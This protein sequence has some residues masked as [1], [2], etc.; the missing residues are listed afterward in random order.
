[1]LERQARI[2]ISGCM[3]KVPVFIYRVASSANTNQKQPVLKVTNLFSQMLQFKGT[4][5]KGAP[6]LLRPPMLLAFGGTPA[7]NSVEVSLAALL[8]LKDPLHHCCTQTAEQCKIPQFPTPVPRVSHSLGMLLHLVY[9]KGEIQFHTEGLVHI[10]KCLIIKH[11]SY[12]SY[13]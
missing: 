8:I 11:F 13:F 10:N 6:A 7:L 4:E 9:L 2:Y 3:L 12:K 1:M 5:P